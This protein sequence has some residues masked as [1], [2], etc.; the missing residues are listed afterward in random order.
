MTSDQIG[1]M[2][3]LAV[4]GDYLVAHP[5]GSLTP[6]EI[7]AAIQIAMWDVEYGA[8]FTYDPLGAPIDGPPPGTSGLVGEYLAD[9]GTGNPWGVYT[10]FTVL[11]TDETVNDQTLIWAA[12]GVHTTGGS[13]EPSTWAMMLLGFAGLGFAGYRRVQAKPALAQQ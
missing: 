3:A 2:G 4:F 1:K 6:D 5:P 9:V 12:P 8:T 13:P 7:A 11:Y 10:G